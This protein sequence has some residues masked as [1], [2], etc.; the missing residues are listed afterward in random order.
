KLEELPTLL[1][2]IGFAGF[3]I[4]VGAL[5]LWAVFGKLIRRPADLES[6]MTPLVGVIGFLSVIGIMIVGDTLAALFF[7]V[8]NQDDFEHY[9]FVSMV[10]A[11]LKI[12]MV[13]GAMAILVK[14]N[15]GYASSLVPPMPRP[16][17][18]ALPLG[19]V[20]WMAMMLGLGFLGYAYV[21][22]AQDPE[23]LAKQD[24]ADLYS[25]TTKWQIPSAFIGAVIAAPLVEEVAF[26]GMLFAGLRSRMGFWAAAALSSLI[27]LLVHNPTGNILFIAPIFGLG[28][29]L[30]YIYETTRNIWYGIAFHAAHNAISLSAMGV[31]G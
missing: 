22:F 27:F 16:H 15:R 13:C 17:E 12:A 23:L 6:P 24:V 29:C 20:G 9:H 26:R 10:G 2:L 25:Q 21:V 19:Y 8:P 30:A 5:V 3:A 7:G 4:G 31:F 1:E 14:R 28:M 18:L 11:I